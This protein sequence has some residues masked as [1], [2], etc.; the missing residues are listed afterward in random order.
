[1][2]ASPPGSG[3]A[4]GW[5]VGGQFPGRTG[6]SHEDNPINT[7]MPST[8]TTESS[9]VGTTVSTSLTWSGANSIASVL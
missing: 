5:P 2:S 1:M 6:S 7:A 8:A 9:S 3:P 4:D